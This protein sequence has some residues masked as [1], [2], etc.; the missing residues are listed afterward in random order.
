M[1]QLCQIQSS[2]IKAEQ[3]RKTGGSGFKLGEFEE[4]QEQQIKGGLDVRKL[5]W[6]YYR[7]IRSH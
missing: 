5:H 6:K 7:G 4:K 1:G 3:S 2:A